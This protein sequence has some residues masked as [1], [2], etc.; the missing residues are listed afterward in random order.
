MALSGNPSQSYLNPRDGFEASIFKAMA[1]SRPVVF[2]AKAT[3][4]VSK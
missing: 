4:Y 1:K 2:E 3:K